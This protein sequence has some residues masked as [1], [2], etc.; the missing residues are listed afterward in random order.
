MSEIDRRIKQM[1][2][3]IISEA[4]ERADEIRRKTEADCHIE[5]Q[6][7]VRVMKQ[8]LDEEYAQKLKDL[9]TKDK[10]LLS[11]VV[12]K[13]RVNK[14]RARESLLNGLQQDALG[15]LGEFAKGKSYA[16]LMQGLLVQGLIKLQEDKLEVQIR[17]EDRE[18]VS[19]LIPEALK[20]VNDLSKGA[21]RT[22][23]VAVSR[24]ALDSELIAGGFIMIA[25][26]G[27]ITCNQTFNERLA[28]AYRDL[29]PEIREKFSDDFSMNPARNKDNKK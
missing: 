21:V 11:T 26:G 5:V 2:S 3:F 12:T 10:V 9:Q 20:I 14:M 25:D 16:I 28:I 24:T 6:N 7:A 18:L 22:S 23:S 19:R 27:R 29:L 17:N 8:Q 15:S 4:E 13:N 1:C